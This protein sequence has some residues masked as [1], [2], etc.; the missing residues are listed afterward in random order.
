[1]MRR[2]ASRPAKSAGLAVN[3]G[4]SSAM[5]VAAIIKSAVRQRGLRPAAMT[6][7][8]CLGVYGDMARCANEWVTPSLGET[9]KPDPTAAELYAKLFPIYRD[10]RTR[11]PPAWAALA[12]ARQVTA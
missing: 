12:E 2:R 1:M 7:A 4:K 3:R 8:V 9:T 6:A 5:A 10:I 11:M